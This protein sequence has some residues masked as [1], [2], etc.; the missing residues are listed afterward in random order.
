MLSKVYG[1]LGTAHAKAIRTEFLR[2]EE[3]RLE[4]IRH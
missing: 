4:K 2:R 1:S 3:V